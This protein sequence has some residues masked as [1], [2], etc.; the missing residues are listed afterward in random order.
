[1]VLSVKGIEAAK[2]KDKPY[3]LS[4][5][6]GLYLYIAPTGRKSWRSN[7]IEL[8]KQKT[9]NFGGY[10]EVG[11][12]EA[13]EKNRLRKLEAKQ[14]KNHI[15]KTGRK[16]RTFKEAGL[17][18]LRV[19]LPTLKN[20]KHQI[21]MRNTIEVYVFPTIG[22]KP[23]DEITRSDLISIVRFMS[24]KGIADSAGRIAGRIRMI[25]D[26]AI[27]CGDIESHPASGL[28]RVIAPRKK[29]AMA[30]IKPSQAGKLLS[31]ILSYP[32]KVTQLGLLLAAHCFPRD[33]ELRSMRF[34]D[35]RWNEKLWVIPEE[36]MKMGKTHVVPLSQQVLKLLPEF[37]TS[38]FVLESPFKPGHSI[39]ENTLLFALYRLGYKG[40]MT[41]HGFRSL[42][43]TVLNES[44]LFPSDAIER[45]LA[46]SETD[47]VRQSYNSAEYLD[48]RKEMMQ[49]YSNWLDT[50][51][52]N[53]KNSSS[54]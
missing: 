4:D 5:R 15:A 12:S 9:V 7:Y 41:T 47:K 34:S 44:G 40:L 31:D 45:Q 8:G 21:Q 2:P 29:I 36:Q 26:Y 6:D 51:L 35:I 10:P 22:E 43:S 25:L 54:G 33:N 28:S 20:P 39:S 18:W 16:I 27:D 32:E 52:E 17:D 53:F 48:Q 49:W 1:M 46:H 30:S 19:K 14:R 24:D 37:G 11:L 23:L 3:K 50:Q 13:R 42:A 38:D